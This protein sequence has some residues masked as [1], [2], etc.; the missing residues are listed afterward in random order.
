MEFG[1]CGVLWAGMLE[2]C[3]NSMK[4]VKCADV[5]FSSDACPARL[6]IPQ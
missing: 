6:E 4:L 1:C 2:E 3:T 5:E